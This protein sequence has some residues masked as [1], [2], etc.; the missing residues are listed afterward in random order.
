MTCRRS[1]SHAEKKDFQASK[2]EGSKKAEF[3][4]VIH[5]FN[6]KQFKPLHG[7]P[8]AEVAKSWPVCVRVA[9]W[10]HLMATS[11][12]RQRVWLIRVERHF[13]L[14]ARERNRQCRRHY[15]ARFLKPALLGFLRNTWV[16]VCVCVCLSFFPFPV[17]G[18]AFWVL[19]SCCDFQQ[20]II[21]LL[22]GYFPLLAQTSSLGFAC[23]VYAAG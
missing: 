13:F 10:T 23:A 12:V 6:E 8:S 20:S 17:R 16:I 14:N 9:T 19:P 4:K 11:D 2:Q 1:Q 5:P 7:R 21:W 3:H 18:Q 15:R 22:S